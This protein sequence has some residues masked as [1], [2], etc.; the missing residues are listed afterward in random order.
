MKKAGLSAGLAD[1]QIIVQGLG[2]VGF[3]AAKFLSEEDDARIVAVVER[4]GVVINAKGIDVEKCRAWM[5]KHGGVKGFPGGTYSSNGARALEMACDILIPSAMENQ[6]THAN[7]ERIDARLVVEAANGPVS[8][9]GDRILAKRGVTVLPDCYVNAGGVVVSYFEWIKNL[10]H[11]RFGRMDRRLDEMRGE[12]I[13]H[14]I[15]ALGG[16]PVP[17]A[18]RMELISRAGELALVRSGLDDTMRNAYHEI[19]GVLRTHKTIRD[20]RTAA[21]YV[22]VRKIGHSKMEMGLC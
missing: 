9:E 5:T 20:Y 10:S 6:I 17:D 21:Y 2:N 15:E 7:A 4:D 8:F 14:A 13:V 16:R 12:R 3:H 19:R 22:A 11:I 18:I 1:K